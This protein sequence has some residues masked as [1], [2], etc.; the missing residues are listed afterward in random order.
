MEGESIEDKDMENES[1]KGEGVE[2][3]G[4]V[5][6]IFKT[7]YRDSG[8]SQNGNEEEDK[9][10]GRGLVFYLHRYQAYGSSWMRWRGV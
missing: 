5:S 10:L 8:R 1:C 6:E 7:P 9:R 2:H 3:K 4:V